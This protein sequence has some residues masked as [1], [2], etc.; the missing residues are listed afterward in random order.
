MA[1]LQLIGFILAV[2]T[3]KVKI[4]ALND[5]KYVAAIIYVTSIVLVVLVLVTFA[6][7]RFLT[8]AEV[9]FS[10]MLMLG[11]TA[12]LSLIFIPK[13]RGLVILLSMCSR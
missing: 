9:F 11:T 13:V 5:S 4:K 8:I 2:Q 10:G 12:F 6:L 3:R 1:L 7:S